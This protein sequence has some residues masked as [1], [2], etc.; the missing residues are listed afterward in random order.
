MWTK[1]ALV[2][3]L[4]LNL[5]L[6]NVFSQEN[7]YPIEINKS[8]S[9]LVVFYQNQAEIYKYT[10][11][12]SS[13]IFLDR[14]LEISRKN[15]FKF[16]E[17]TILS[18]IGGNLYILGEYD[19]SLDYFTSGFNIF[20]ELNNKKGI[21]VGYNNSG[22]IYNIQG[23]TIKAIN[24]HKKSL[25]ICKVIN[26]S[27]LM[28]TNLFNLGITYE[29]N[30]DYDSAIIFS[31]KG[32]L[33]SKL[34]KNNHQILMIYN[35]NGRIYTKMRLFDNAEEMFLKIIE[36]PNYNNLWEISY[37]HSGLA[38][39]YQIQKLYDKSIYHGKIAYELAD[40]INAKWDIQSSSEILSVAYFESN[41]SDSA[42]K[43]L[44]I[45]KIY[46]DSIFN[47]EKEKH[48]NY[49]NLK[50]AEYQNEKLTK[51]KLIQQNQIDTKNILIIIFI[52][53]L[54]ILSVLL[55]IIILNNK[56]KRYLNRKLIYQ[57]IEI[58][59][60]NKELEKLN[61]TK[62]LMFR[63]IAHD[64]LSPL[65]TVVSYTDL[66]LK[67][68]SSMN[69]E[70]V[71]EIMRKFNVST[72]Q[73]YNLLE[74]LL[75]WAKIQMGEISIYPKTILIYDLV[76]MVT[77]IYETAFKSKDL[78]FSIDIDN[79]IEVFVDKNMISTVIRNLISNAIKFTP[80]GGSI[81]IKA[82]KK[83]DEVELIITDTGVGIDEADIL[84]L[85]DLNPSFTTIGTSGEKG[86][87]IGLML[88]REFVEKAN[89]KIWAESKPGVG[90][91]F[92]FTIPAKEA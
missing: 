83:Y 53:G 87:G 54:L 8:D 10:N 66:I 75:D 47:K 3:L 28:A 50:N 41:Q 80:K 24:Y 38:S 49:I 21:A 62:D 70:E 40:K 65:S 86:S 11:P 12:D 69:K 39:L 43:Y 17:A 92:H 72:N 77:A 79:K 71:L 5:T 45:S 7:E 52:I 33:I 23:R 15:K 48:I 68:K 58:E 6:Y 85:F 22:M 19:L 42:Y 57:N 4:S 56:Q 13:R 32:L 64:L 31:N 81:S 37:A 74:N 44:R 1:I 36:A 59:L 14:A 2:F 61:S 51:D 63:I 67:H 91:Q 76:K 89:G 82:H 16:S 46:S 30:K 73:A 34:Q 18:K 26:D 35:L 84:K 88:C 29:Q 9:L 20:K 55:L 60:K 78:S 27:T 90:T 25:A